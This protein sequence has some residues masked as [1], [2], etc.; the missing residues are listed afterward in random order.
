LRFYITLKNIVPH[1][2]CGHN[3][4]D[5]KFEQVSESAQ[6][7]V[8][9]HIIAY[10]VTHYITARQFCTQISSGDSLKVNSAVPYQCVLAETAALAVPQRFASPKLLCSAE[11]H[12]SSQ[13]ERSLCQTRNP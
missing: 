10:H 13:E 5:I 8:G 7:S 9:Q 11:F 6:A 12:K 4:C 2:P 1:L 3:T